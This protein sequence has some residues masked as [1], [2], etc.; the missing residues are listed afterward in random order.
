[1]SQGFAWLIWSVVALALGVSART[2]A[3]ERFDRAARGIT[4]AL[5][6]WT[7]PVILRAFLMVL[8]A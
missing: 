8:A 2:F 7:A 4:I 5:A 6:V 3:L 1:M